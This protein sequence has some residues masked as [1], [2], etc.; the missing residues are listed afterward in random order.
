MKKKPLFIVLA[1]ATLSVAAYLRAKATKLQLTFHTAVTANGV[2]VYANFTTNMAA[3]CPTYLLT[4][5]GMAR[6]LFTVA[7][8]VKQAYLVC[9]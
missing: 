8:R 9:N 5:G 2:R 1:F 6:T 7:Y 4:A 3:G